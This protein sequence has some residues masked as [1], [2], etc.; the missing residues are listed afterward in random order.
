MAEDLGRKVSITWGGVA[1]AGLRER[2]I[3]INGEPVDVSSDEDDGWQKLLAEPGMKSVAVTLSGV[4]K[5]AALKNDW[6]AGNRQKAV[7]ITYPD[8]ATISATFHMASYTDTGP[9]S[10]A[11]TFETELR[12]TGAVAY[13]P[14]A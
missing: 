9:Y 13:T 10:D 5:S 4:T 12:S 1:I 7:V 11:L 3:A 6:F 14:G 8:G 2:G